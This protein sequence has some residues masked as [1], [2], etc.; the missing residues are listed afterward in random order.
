MRNLIKIYKRLERGIS[1][2]ANTTKIVQKSEEA[3]RVEEAEAAKEAKK[4][5]AAKMAEEA[6]PQVEQITC[7]T[8]LKKGKYDGIIPSYKQHFIEKGRELLDEYEGV[9]RIYVETVIEEIFDDIL[10]KKVVISDHAYRSYPKN[11]K[12]SFDSAKNNKE[13]LAATFRHREEEISKVLS[14]IESNK[15]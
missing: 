9:V 3:K 13:F 4:V 1:S 15:K 5:E 8:I 6:K 10:N 11:L 14:I 12:R 7:S 2:I